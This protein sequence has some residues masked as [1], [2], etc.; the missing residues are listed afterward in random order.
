MAGCLEL[1]EVENLV[2]GMSGRVL[3]TDGAQIWEVGEAEKW[4]LS[5][6]EDWDLNG[7]ENWG[8]D[9]AEV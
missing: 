9:V 8:L 2:L 1:G 6:V 5:K 7:S 3:G 4:G